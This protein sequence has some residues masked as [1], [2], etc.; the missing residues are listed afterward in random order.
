MILVIGTIVGIAVWVGLIG[1]C[2]IWWGM[3]RNRQEGLPEGWQPLT[4]AQAA[5]HVDRLWAARA[6]RRRDSHEI[7][8]P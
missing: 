4:E 6:T 7:L 1:I 2:L 3:Y 8:S 5:E